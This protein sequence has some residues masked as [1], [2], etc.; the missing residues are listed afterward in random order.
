MRTYFFRG[1]IDT[2][3]DNLKK[4]IQNYPFKLSAG[5][6]VISKEFGRTTVKEVFFDIDHGENGLQ[7]VIVN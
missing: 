2:K 3:W 5:D 6:T 1:S 4:T 7:F